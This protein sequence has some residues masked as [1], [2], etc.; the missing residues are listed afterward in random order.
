MVAAFRAPF[1]GVDKSLLLRPLKT[2]AIRLTAVISATVP[3]DQESDKVLPPLIIA[4]YLELCSTS[5]TVD[6]SARSVGYEI[7]YGLLMWGLS[8]STRASTS[9]KLAF[10]PMVFSQSKLLVSYCLGKMVLADL[11]FARSCSRSNSRRRFARSHTVATKCGCSAHQRWLLTSS[12]HLS[13]QALHQ[14]SQ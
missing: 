10:R 4:A 1:K 6:F 13:Q 12:F 9:W 7:S 5:D 8:H 14:L 3:K 2:L 11:T